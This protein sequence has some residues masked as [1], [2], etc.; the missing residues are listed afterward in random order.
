MDWHIDGRAESRGTI[1]IASGSDSFAD[2]VGEMVAAAG[3]SPA[4]LAGTESASLSLTRTQPA[5]VICDCDVAVESVRQLIVEVSAR[6]IPMLLSGPG[7]ADAPEWHAAQVRAFGHRVGCITLPMAPE[8]F[9]AAVD[10]LS[11]AV[12]ERTH[13]ARLRVAG[14][15]I[16]AGIRVRSLSFGLGRSSQS[17]PPRVPNVAKGPPIEKLRRRNGMFLLPSGDDESE[18][19]T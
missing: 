16:E 9:N 4:F 15:S 2:I 12:R 14:A 7:F 17:S 6:R 5:I 1:L 19:K 18:S 3:F 10:A 13:H 11:P 8:A